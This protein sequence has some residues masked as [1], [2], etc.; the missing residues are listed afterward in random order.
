MF[1]PH[2][3]RSL[4]AYSLWIGQKRTFQPRLGHG[5]GGGGLECIS[6]R[7]R[8]WLATGRVSWILRALS[9]PSPL[10]APGSQNTTLQVE[11]Q[12]STPDHST[13]KDWRILTPGAAPQEPTQGSQQWSPK[14]TH[15]S[16]RLRDS[17][18]VFSPI[19]LPRSRQPRITR[20]MREAVKME[21]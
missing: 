19:L 18:Q 4:K 21:D 7:P 5:G 9:W 8:I 16:D 17:N 20:Y 6:N 2:R 11:D 12:K 15:L 3:G 10:P 13:R 1:L 14:R